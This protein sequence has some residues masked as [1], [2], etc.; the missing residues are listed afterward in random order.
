MKIT[1]IKA[2]SVKGNFEWVLIKIFTDN[3][4]IY[5]LGESFMGPGVKELVSSEI[6][7][8]A[9]SRI[10]SFK[11]QLVGKDPT[12]VERLIRR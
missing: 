4:E 7:F 3:D 1:D 11:D 8:G 6:S 9:G 2:T 10:F 5:G 12:N